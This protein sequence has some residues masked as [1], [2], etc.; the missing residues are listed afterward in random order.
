MNVNIKW[1]NYV[2]VRS[3]WHT[4][5]YDGNRMYAVE[6][7]AGGGGNFTFDTPN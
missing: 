2:H 6:F 7:G 3:A 1:I 5:Y 4:V